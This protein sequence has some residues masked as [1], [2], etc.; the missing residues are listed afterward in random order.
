MK[1]RRL[2]NFLIIYINEIS[3][4]AS[5]KEVYENLSYG[6]EGSMNI[7]CKVKG[8]YEKFIYAKKGLLYAAL[9]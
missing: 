3:F 1:V 7:W 6:K 5:V 9:S 8:V 4:H 2:I